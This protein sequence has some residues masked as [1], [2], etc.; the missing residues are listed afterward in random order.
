MPPPFA[1]TRNL[2]DVLALLDTDFVE[3]TA[4]VADGAYAI[5]LG[6]GISFDQMPKLLDL[7]EIVRRQTVTLRAVK[8]A[9]PCDRN[10][11]VAPTLELIARKR[12]N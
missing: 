2:P 3:L 7:P 5:W 4:G 11:I 9:R 10:L 12:E 6:S 1:A 8:P